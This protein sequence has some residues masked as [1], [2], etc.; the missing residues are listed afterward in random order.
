MEKSPR[1]TATPDGILLVDKPA[2]ISS[3]DVVMVA[4]RAVGERRIGHAGTLDPFATGL[5]VM[6]I[7]RA[8]RLL[9]YLPGEPKV[10]DATISFGAET[11]TEDL[12]GTVVRTG[13][14]PPK[15]AIVAAIPALTGEIDQ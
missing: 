11:D 13:E 4:R 9:P 6:L 14:P 10:Y 5:L 3:H 7:G 1:M 12:H 15:S 2:G 8:T